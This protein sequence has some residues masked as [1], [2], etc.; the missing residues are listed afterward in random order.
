MKALARQYFWWPD[1]N[2]QIERFVE[3]CEACMTHAN[4]PE[5]TSLI[6]FKEAE[7]VFDRIHINGGV[8]VL[9]LI[10][11]K[12]LSKTYLNLTDAYSK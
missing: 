9:P 2:Q 3:G 12:K 1:L 6:N 8:K 10:G 7:N 4:N 5:K 11:P